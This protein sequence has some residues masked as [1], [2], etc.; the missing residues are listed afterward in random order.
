MH[1]ARASGLREGRLTSL[2]ISNFQEASIAQAHPDRLIKMEAAPVEVVEAVGE[3]VVVGVLVG[4]ARRCGHAHAAFSK[5]KMVLT[6]PPNARGR[7]MK[8][9]LQL[10]GSAATAFKIMDGATMAKPRVG[11]ARRVLQW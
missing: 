4:A 11:T 3:E 7:W 2:D 8:H 10:L 5:V 9:V 1:T 6:T